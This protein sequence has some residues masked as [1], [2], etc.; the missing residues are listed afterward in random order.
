MQGSAGGDPRTRALRPAVL[1]H[2]GRQDLPAAVRR[3]DDA[4]RQGHCAAHV[5]RGGPHRSRDAAHAV[6]AVAQAPGALLHRILRPRPD[7]GRRRVPRRRGTRHVDGPVASFPRAHRD[8]C[9]G[10]LRPRVLLV[11]LGAH[12]HGRRRRHGAARRPAAAGHGV[13]AVPSHRHL[14]CGLPDHRRR[15]A[16]KA[17]TSPIRRASASW[18]ATRRT[19]R[20][21]LR[22]T[23]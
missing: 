23:S 5:R 8:P 15:R 10:R 3:H 13:R 16:A 4:L 7:H 6:P 19:R 22:A 9:H 1:A 21:S 20:T 2:R 14:R 17:A 11:H 12:L 18:N